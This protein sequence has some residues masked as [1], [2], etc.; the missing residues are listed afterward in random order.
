[1]S[2]PHQGNLNL[3]HHVEANYH[4]G[5][6]NFFCALIIFWFKYMKDSFVCFIA[7]VLSLVLTTTLLNMIL[8]VVC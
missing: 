2:H 1:M 5:N 4:Q 7:L 6:L 8:D 3:V